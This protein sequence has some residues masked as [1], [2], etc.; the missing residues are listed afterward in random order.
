MATENTTPASAIADYFRFEDEIAALQKA[1]DEDEFVI[2]QREAIAARQEKMKKI[3]AWMLQYCNK[4]NLDKV[5]A[6]NDEFIKDV[7]VHY[8]I[9]SYEQ[10]IAWMAQQEEVPFH[11]FNKKLTGK[12]IDE[13]AEM[14]E[15][16]L[17]PGISTFSKVT[18]KFKRGKVK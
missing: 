3:E 7:A 18:P 11:F 17:P 15:G 8:N 1:L 5:K 13:F 14:N 12:S 9:A 2:Q 4:A 10:L 16:T 6:G